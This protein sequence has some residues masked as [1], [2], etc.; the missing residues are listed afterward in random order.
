[1]KILH[2]DPEPPDDGLD[3]P[4]FESAGF[5]VNT[6]RAGGEAVRLGAACRPDILITDWLLPETW[7]HGLH[8]VAALRRLRP[9]LRVFLATEVAT[10]DVG[11]DALQ[12]G[13][14]D[15]LPKSISPERL[16]STVQS[17]LSREPQARRGRSVYPDSLLERILEA[18][19]PVPGEECPFGG[20]ALIVDPSPWTRR[21]GVREL[22]RI[23][24]VAHSVS[25]VD[26]ALRI[27]DR[28]PEIDVV[29]FDV[30]WD[31]LE[32]KSLVERLMVDHPQVI[33][34]A[35]GRDPSRLRQLS[36]KPEHFLQL[37]WSGKALMDLML[38]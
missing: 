38:Q 19:P 11:F 8:L 2:V 18:D 24:C 20:R 12:L 35:Q 10:P 23:F 3:F 13:V 25:D 4:A 22:E 34:I 27:L 37:P 29:I 21:L 15:I 16:V 9:D 17:A 14:H 36:W 33:R 5:R 32:V 28:D 30:D 6:V 31:R 1:M 7:F 26:W